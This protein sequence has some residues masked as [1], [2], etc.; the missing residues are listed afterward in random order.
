[1]SLL[2]NCKLLIF[3]DGRHGSTAPQKRQELVNSGIPKSGRGCLCVRLCTCSGHGMV[4]PVSQGQKGRAGDTV[5]VARA[6]VAALRGR[7]D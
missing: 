1:M 3:G 7:R 5:V 6:V 2:N 4:S